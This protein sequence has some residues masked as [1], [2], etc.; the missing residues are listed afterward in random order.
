MPPSRP[1]LLS[2]FSSSGLLRCF[3]ALPHLVTGHY[4]TEAP[5]R[6]CWTNPP[7][8]KVGSRPISYHK[9]QQCHYGPIT[10][11]EIKCRRVLKGIIWAILVFCPLEAEVEG[12]STVCVALLPPVADSGAAVTVVGG[13]EEQGTNRYAFLS[14]DA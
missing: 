8:E 5:R 10:D 1:F 11:Q 3:S 4:P 6:L 2:L 12:S 14:M 7:S 13:E 9:Q